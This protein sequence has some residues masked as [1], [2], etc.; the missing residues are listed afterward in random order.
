MTIIDHDGPIGVASR[1]QPVQDALREARTA[2][3]WAD[4]PAALIGVCEALAL[5][6][7]HHERAIDEIRD[8]LRRDEP[9][10]PALGTPEPQPPSPSGRWREFASS[11]NGDRW[12][13]D[14]DDATGIAHVIHKANEPSGGAVTT[15]ELGVFLNRGPSAPE[16]LGLLRLIGSLVA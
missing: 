10:T 6:A 7:E 16:M 14:R 15:I 4:I 3:G 9:T 5:Q 12:Y 1:S 2:A 11:S 13:L 8:R